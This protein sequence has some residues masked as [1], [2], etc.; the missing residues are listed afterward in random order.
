MAL[1]Y[2]PLFLLFYKF[3][4]EIL[5]QLAFNKRDNYTRC[6]NSAVYLL[7]MREHSRSEIR[8]KLK[9]K[10]CSDNVDLDAL[11]D[12]LEEKDYLNEE[13]FTESFIRYRVSRGQG[14]IKIVNELKIRGISSYLINRSI[15]KLEIDWE[16]VAIEQREKKFGDGQ[17]IDIREKARQVRFLSGRGF[18]FRIIYSVVD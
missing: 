15:Q 5:S 18:P 10:E 4:G 7:A 16:Q 3:L 17:P 2:T 8:N 14:S 13:R 9:R 11:L 1:I 6:M 12:K